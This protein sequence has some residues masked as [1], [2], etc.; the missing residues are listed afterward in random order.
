MARAYSEIAFTPAVR[1]F[2]TRMGSRRNYAALDHAAERGDTL[3]A[4]EAEFI[5]ERDGF[6]QASVGENGWPYVQFRGGPA[7]FLRL[8]DQRTIGYADFRGNVQYISAGNIEA[9]GRVS[10][11]LMDYAQRRRLKIWGRAR[12]VD[13]ADDPALIAR[14]EDGNYRAR[15]ERAVLISVEA[16]DWNCPQ[17][18]T[19]RFTEAEI[20]ERTRLLD[21]E[22]APLQQQLARSRST[23]PGGR[24]AAA[25]A[26]E[27]QGEPGHLA[28]LGSGPLALV[29]AGV[30]QLTP[31][32][33][34]YELRSPDGADLPAIGAG[35]HIDV[36]LALPNRGEETRRYSISSNPARRDAYEI[37]V[38][39]E[40]G[41][42]GGWVA[43]HAGWRLGL[44]LRCKPPGNDFAL[45][46]DQRPAVLIAGGIGITPIKAMALQL[47]A[48]QSP[49]TLHYAGRSV[50]EMAYRDRLERQFGARLTTYA[51]DRG[52]RLDV[53]KLFSEAPPE[54]LFYVCGPARLLDAVRDGA[55]ATGVAANRLR[56]ERFHVPARPDDLPLQVT[57]RGSG[58]TIDVAAGQ[59]ILDAVHAAGI[60]AA[61]GC[62]T[63][64]CGTC[65]V[66]VLAGTPDHRDSALSEGERERA[67]LMCICVSRARSAALTL[68]L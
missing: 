2:Q 20:A 14:L 8:L 7:G 56:F 49:F 10:L 64:S 9:D 39:R 37:A 47:Q 67:G 40:E 6:Y 45:H 28:V 55:A 24:E 17:H 19:P 18:I 62:R 5:A 22:L 11:I 32:V 12:L 48:R 61:A 36:P 21:A 26:P 65:A 51:S 50:R 63:G 15:V 44:Q 35:A 53:Q 43:I 38:L 30:R 60:A 42:S 41:G 3:G 46:D 54:A 25:A 66:K 4:S 13:E 59:S 68:D 31:R 34:A 27:G 58:R 33:R 57:L 16:F 23:A 52:Q 1:A 29:V